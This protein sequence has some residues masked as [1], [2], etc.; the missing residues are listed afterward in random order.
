MLIFGNHQF[1]LQVATKYMPVTNRQ[2]IGVDL[3][4]I[5]PIPNVT[6]FAEDIT[7]QRCR[8]LLKKELKDRKADVYV[9]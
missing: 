1:R 8:A 6:T 3:V 7:G 4:P 2:I 5:K 9:L